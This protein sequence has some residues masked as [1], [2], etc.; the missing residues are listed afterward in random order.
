MEIEQFDNRTLLSSIAGETASGALLQKFGT[1]TSLAQASFEELTDV[2]G[3]GESRAKAIKSAFLLAQRLSKE[4][5]FEPPLLDTPDKVADLLREDN[6]LYRVE[7][8]QV[9]LLNTRRRLIGVHSISQGTLDT[10][11]VH[12]REVFTP[13]I[14]KRASAIIMVHNHPSGD[15]TASD[16]DIRITRDFIRAGQLLRIEVLDH[17]ILGMRTTERPK[18][19][20][21]LRE[22]GY[23]A[24]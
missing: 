22:L 13:A 15:P 2:P 20:V 24:G 10:L 7:T 23:W 1:L 12:A 9:V 19:Y 16:A 14:Q 5:H 21:S 8:F 6:R 17:I 18:D 11:L 3:I 4:I